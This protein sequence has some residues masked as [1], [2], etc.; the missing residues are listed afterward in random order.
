MMCTVLFDFH[1]ELVPDAKPAYDQL[2][3]HTDNSSF[4]LGSWIS[5]LL[6][7][8][9]WVNHHNIKPDFEKMLGYVQC[10][11]MSLEGSTQ[12]DLPLTVKD[13]LD[14]EGYKG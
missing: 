8:Y 14:S 6:W 3:E 9:R 4:S 13:M 11:V 7:V 10:C 12:G 2:V 1:T 5:G